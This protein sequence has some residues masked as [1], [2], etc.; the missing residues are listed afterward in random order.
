VEF[1]KFS[2]FNFLK[3]ERPSFLWGLIIVNVGMLGFVV[4]N[5]TQKIN[6][7]KSFSPLK[8]GEQVAELPATIS[9]SKDTVSVSKGKFLLGVIIFFNSTHADQIRKIDRLRKRFSNDCAC[10]I[11]GVFQ[12]GSSEGQGLITDYALQMPVLADP[13]GRISRQFHFRSEH[14]LGG[15]L[16]VDDSLRVRLHLQSIVPDTLLEELIIRKLES[17]GHGAHSIVS[18]DNK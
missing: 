2:E 9:I 16:I 3:F 4:H 6:K 7:A 8:W 1:G 5:L 18:A 14:K 15:T 11:L 17:I 13:S 12:G 10:Q